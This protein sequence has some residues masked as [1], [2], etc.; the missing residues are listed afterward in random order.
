MKGSPL[1]AIWTFPTVVFSAFLMAWGAEAAQFLIAQGLAL[2]LL[3]WL[4][5]LPEFAVEAV[6][7]WKAGQDPSL[8]HLVIANFTGSIRLLVGLGW[9][10][11]GLI[12]SIS[13]KMKG[14]RLLENIYLEEEHS[15]EIY[16]MLVPM[17]YFLLIWG[18]GTLT[19][20]DGIILIAMYVAYILV[21]L[22]LPHKEM[23]EAE[24]LPVAARWALK[25]NRKLVQWLK[26]LALLF[27]GAFLIFLVAEP[28]VTSMLAV[29]VYF[30][31][32]EF[33]FVQWV[34]PFLSEFPEKV[35][36]FNWARQPTKATMGIMNFVSSNI[37]QW[38]VL[39]GLIP[40]IFAISHGH[41]APIV[42]DTL[43]KHE[44]MLTFAQ[45]LFAFTILMDMAFSFWEAIILFILFA[46][47]FLFPSTRIVVTYLYFAASAFVLLRLMIEGK[48]YQS[49][50]A[51]H[52]VW[53]TRVIRTVK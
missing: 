39:S 49:I 36:A 32:S 11:V 17:L 51:L 43:Q 31:V 19:V 24:D 44:I 29:A 15:V 38:S 33:F 50:R 26:V 8:T 2:A 9:P 30:G 53:T 47:Q 6:I 18:K 20:F 40:I 34:A 28:F 16:G 1:S 21:L 48:A 4:Q 10:M 7:A 14:G 5:T 41:M 42:L 13:R 3:A 35:S 52:R 27:L 45:S 12:H 22:R 25:G 46:V 37:N 23:E